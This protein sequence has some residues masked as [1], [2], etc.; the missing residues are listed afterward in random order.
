M[1]ISDLEI[2]DYI[3]E[4][5]DFKIEISLYFLFPLVIYFIYLIFLNLKTRNSFSQF[6]KLS[7]YSVKKKITSIILILLCSLYEIV[8][9]F[10]YDNH[11]S[12]TDEMVYIFLL[13]LKIILLILIIFQIKEESIKTKKSKNTY[14]LIF[15]IIFSIKNLIELKYEYDYVIVIIIIM[16]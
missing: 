16:H 13:F 2:K 10:Y 6:K 8:L 4:F 15:W 9:T 1:N 5:F 3:Q 7:L 14:F 12:K 11:I